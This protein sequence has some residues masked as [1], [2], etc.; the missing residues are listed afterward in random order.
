MKKTIFVLLLIL[1]ALLTACTTPPS[2]EP[3]T[4]PTP[5]SE[6][7][8]P[9]GISEPTTPTETTAPPYP[10]DP[11][12]PTMPSATG[13]NDSYYYDYEEYLQLEIDPSIPFIPYEQIQ[14]LGE[15]R[16]FIVKRK[17]NSLQTLYSLSNDG[18]VFFF[19]YSDSTIR[20]S[21]SAGTK[22]PIPSVSEMR[23]FGHSVGDY[24]F[25]YHG[26]RY[27]FIWT[28]LKRI[29]WEIDGVYYSISSGVSPHL[30]NYPV[31]PGDLV[32]DFLNLDTAEDALA[33]FRDMISTP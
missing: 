11:V 13:I 7:T 12:K 5:S 15:F 3:T 24:G 14:F 17:N 25:I 9:T 31:I 10:S 18:H 30:D 32:S 29:E 1:A 23:K 27:D 26:I 28:D 21:Y 6:P 4:S 19:S 2:T 22:D 16:A 20:D 33:R 8:I